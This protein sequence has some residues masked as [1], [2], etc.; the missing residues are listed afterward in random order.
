[1]NS[2]AWLVYTVVRLLAFLVPF[3]VIM[4]TLPGWQ[5]NWTLGAAVGAVVSALVSFIF[6]TPQR[7]AMAAGMAARR[8]KP[9]DRSADELAEDAEAERAAASSSIEREGAHA[10]ALDD[11]PADEHFDEEATPAASEVEPVDG[12]PDPED[13]DASVTSSLEHAPRD[14][15]TPH[16]PHDADLRA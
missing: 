7:D 13:L 8:P 11:A 14:E 6:L 15:D 3:G 1:M 16:D 2:R 5:W 10:V 12:A 4:L 9:K